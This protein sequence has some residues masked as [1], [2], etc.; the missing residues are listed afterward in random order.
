MPNIY[1]I[2][3]LSGYKNFSLPYRKILPP[4]WEIAGKMARPDRD[5]S[6]TPARNNREISAKSAR[7]IPSLTIINNNINKITNNKNFPLQLR[8]KTGIPKAPGLSS[9]LPGP[10]FSGIVRAD[11]PASSKARLMKKKEFP[12]ILLCRSVSPRSPSCWFSL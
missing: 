2:N 1:N 10:R 12:C 8:S 7:K 5:F 6:A 9:P 11:F 3:R 4:K